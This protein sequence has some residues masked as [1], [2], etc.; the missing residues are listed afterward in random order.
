MRD[1]STREEHRREG[2]YKHAR[3]ERPSRDF[4]LGVPRGLDRTIG[5]E[6]ARSV[7]TREGCWSRWLGIESFD[8]V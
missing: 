3:Q 5:G 2:M 8:V 7:A 4:W 1:G 6:F